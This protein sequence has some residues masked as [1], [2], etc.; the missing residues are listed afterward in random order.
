MVDLTNYKLTF[1]DEFDALSVS[2]TGSGTTWSDIRPQWRQDAESDTG[3][4]QSSFVDPGS[5]YNPFAVSGGAL[6]ITAVP[7]R[8]PY[9]V[10]GSWESGLI[11]TQ[12]HFSQ[13]YGYFEMRVETASAPGSWDAF[14]LLPDHPTANQELDVMEHLGN[15]DAGTYSTIHTA[16]GTPAQQLQVYSRDAARESGFHTYGMD[17]EKDRISFY[18]DGQLMGSQATPSDMHSP[19]YILADLATENGAQGPSITTKIDYIRAFSKEPDARAVA[20]GAVSAPD[21]RDPDLHGAT[22]AAN[23]PAAGSATVGDAQSSAAGV[24]PGAGAPS[25]SGTSA[26]PSSPSAASSSGAPL[27]SPSPA[28]AAAAPAD[29]PASVSGSAATHAISA[30][31]AAAMASPATSSPSP[32]PT[33]PAGVPTSANASVAAQ[34]VSTAAAA[35]VASPSPVPAPASTTSAAAASITVITRRDGSRV[36]DV[37]AGGQTLHADAFT[38]FLNHGQGSNAFVFDPGYG[39]DVVRQLRIGGPS[40]DVIDLPSSDFATIADVLR[41]TRDAGN[42]AVI[43]DPAS[44]DTLRLTGVSKAQLAHNPGVFTLHA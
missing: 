14:W 22:V 31:A 29:I 36:V 44:G 33:P 37:G 27:V 32:G 13:T 4:G 41:H 20:Q 25:A 43:R 21:G 40:H 30:A 26:S 17:W 6:S 12:G 16:D 3:F 18:V 23:A 24:L 8:T 34:S 1:D 28:A 7:D 38:T 35:A 2:Q 15:D 10:P 19:M 42:A 5:G 11:S 9:G 39:L